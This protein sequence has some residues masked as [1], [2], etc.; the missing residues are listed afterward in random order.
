MVM[1]VRHY[2]RPAVKYQF[3]Y[4]GPNLRTSF[5]GGVFVWSGTSEEAEMSELL[6]R[7]LRVKRRLIDRLMGRERLYQTKLTDGQS[8]AYGR[9]ATPLASQQ[10]AQR[11]WDAR[12]GRD[13]N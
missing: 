5:S 7:T 10:R 6:S 13:A 9:G 1:L 11:N 3:T 2:W 8:V 12:V 4:L